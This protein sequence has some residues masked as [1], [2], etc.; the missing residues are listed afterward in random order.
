MKS[1]ALLIGAVLAVT[2]ASAAVAQPAQPDLKRGAAL[3]GQVCVACHA[4][5]G[6]STTAANPKLAQQHPE[7]LIKQ[8]QEYKSGKRANAV[9]VGFA[10]QLSDQDMRDIAYWL[11]S[12]KATTGAA[13]DAEKVRLGERIYRGG[14]MDRRIPACAGCH[15]PRG[16]GIPAE[17][18]RLS[19]QHAEYTATQLKLFRTNERANNKPMHEIAR[20][21]TDVEIAA[22]ADYIAGL[23]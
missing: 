21:L 2:F 12:Q 7:Y 6:N 20:Y 4:A 17:Y 1:K 3:Y 13:T 19:G 23:R 14:L 8:L 22:L 18:P 16:S 11:A 15:G 10:S 9:M 5:D